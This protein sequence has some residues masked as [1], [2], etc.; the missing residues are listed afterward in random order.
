M[1]VLTLSGR[2]DKIRRRRKSYFPKPK[3][4]GSF[5]QYSCLFV[6]Q[7]LDLVR[8][9][10]VCLNGGAMDALTHLTNRL[11]SLI[12]SGYWMSATG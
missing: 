2:P 7:R 4:T 8:C 3:K 6:R 5:Q 10:G 11:N 1:C 9:G 12:N